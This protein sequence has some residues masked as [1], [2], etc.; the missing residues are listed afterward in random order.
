M[1]AARAVPLKGKT[2]KSSGPTSSSSAKKPAEKKASQYALRSCALLHIRQQPSGG[3]PNSSMIPKLKMQHKL[4]RGHPLQAN[5]RPRALPKKA[6][7]TVPDELIRAFPD[8]WSAR[9][10]QPMHF[11]PLLDSPLNVPKSLLTPGQRE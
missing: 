10:S 9:L 1:F 3:K 7:E 6:D 4:T 2:S 5:I 11:R 8:D